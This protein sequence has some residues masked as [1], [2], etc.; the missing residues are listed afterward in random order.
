MPGTFFGLSIGTSGL[1][2][3]QAG[4]NTTTHNISNTETEGY[5]R[6]IAKQ[7]ASSALRVNSSYGMAG[8]GVDI[9]GVE[10]V[11]DTYYD[12]KYRINNT[13]YGAYSTKQYYMNSIENYFNEVQ[14]KGFTTNFDNMYNAFHELSKNPTDLT[15]RTQ[16]ASYAQSTTQFINSLA[17]SLEKIQEECNFE[18]RN[19]ISRINSLSQ[20]IATVT[21]QINTLEVGGGTSN[22]LRD[23]RNLMVEELSSYCNITVKEKVAGDGVGVTT[24]TVKMDGQTLV[25]TYI[26]NELQVVPRTEKANM[27]DMEGL[28]DIYWAGGQK[29]NTHSPTLGGTLRALFEVRDGNNAENFSG[30]VTADSGDMTITITNT[31]INSMMDLNIPATGV[32]TIG[33]RL[34]HYNGFAVMQDEDTGTFQYEFS[35]DEGIVT[36]VN[37]TMVKVGQSISYK[38]I[39]YYMG[40]LNK[41]VRT[42]SKAFNDI[43]KSGVDLNGDPGLEFFNGTDLVTGENFSFVQSPT[44]EENNYLFTSKTGFYA[45]DYVDDDKNYGSYYLLIAKNFCITDEV[46]YNPSKLVTTKDIAEG[47]G[48]NDL[49]EKLIALKDDNSMFKQGKPAQFFQTLV[50]EIGIDTKKTA[51]FSENQK[52]I[53]AAVDNQRLSISGVDTEEEAMNLIRYQNA[54]SLSAKAISVMDECFD[55]LINYMGA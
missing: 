16:A 11:R 35:L 15:V 47:V 25:D 28:Y 46:Y 48:N 44:E 8:S 34:Y 53:L 17:S 32:L 12:E 19:Q 37:D 13:M 21:K 45:S 40:E 20:Q 2:A 24:F 41:F 9:T 7:Q 33:N 54:Y 50:A 26:S 55:K 23:Q 52:D 43:C 22:D 14:L 10:Q 1:Y 29:V 30:K 6:Q 4:L 3:S 36:D 18:I 49:M 27:N 42:F 31:N 39:P 5:S 38:G 51:N